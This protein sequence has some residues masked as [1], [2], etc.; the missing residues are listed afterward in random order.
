MFWSQTDPGLNLVS[1]CQLYNLMC[2]FSKLEFLYILRIIILKSFSSEFWLLRSYF[3]QKCFFYGIHKPNIIYHFVFIAIIIIVI[4]SKW[5]LKLPSLSQENSKSKEIN[6]KPM[7]TKN[8]RCIAIEMCF[9][10]PWV[11]HIGNC[12]QGRIVSYYQSYTLV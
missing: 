12:L 1:S 11:H 7:T 2:F 10:I 3:L 9:S 8:L 4:N 5:I 6:V